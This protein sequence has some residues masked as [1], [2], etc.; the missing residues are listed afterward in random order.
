MG[1]LPI[2]AHD[3]IIWIRESWTSQFTL[4]LKYGTKW[5]WTACVLVPY[6][7]LIYEYITC[8]VIVVVL[9]YFVLF[10]CLLALSALW[11]LANVVWGKRHE[12]FF[13]LFLLFLSPSE[14]S[15]KA[16]LLWCVLCLWEWRPSNLPRAVVLEEFTLVDEKPTCF[17]KL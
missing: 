15:V 11:N 9:F 14:F 4:S 2:W 8:S 3:R 13:S 12:Q 10:S 1:H 5:Q 16:C 6:N 7:H 17:G